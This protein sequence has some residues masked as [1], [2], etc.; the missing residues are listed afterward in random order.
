MKHNDISFYEEQ[1]KEKFQKSKFEDHLKDQEMK[2]K[3]NLKVLLALLKET[4]QLDV[5]LEE[6]K[7]NFY[8]HFSTDFLEKVEN[9]KIVLN[10]IDRFAKKL[11]GNV[12]SEDFSLARLEESQKLL[13]DLYNN[14]FFVTLH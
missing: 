13:D 1:Q 7:Q 8:T 5:Q 9:L 4:Q 14:L 3:S 10:E 2:F 12:L 11:K 6:F